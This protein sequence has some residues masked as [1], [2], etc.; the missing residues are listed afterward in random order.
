M[1]LDDDGR[2]RLVQPPSGKTFE[3]R[4]PGQFVRASWGDEREAQ[5]RKL[6]QEGYSCSQIAKQLGG[7]TRNAVIGKVH[8]LG[9]ALRGHSQNRTIPKKGHRTARNRSQQEYA[10]YLEKA[11]LGDRDGL[12]FHKGKTPV[13]IAEPFPPRQETDIARISFM[14]LEDGKHCKF[15]PGDPV[16]PYEKQFCGLDVIAPGAVYCPAHHARCNENSRPRNYLPKVM[17]GA[18]LGRDQLENVKEFEDAN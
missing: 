3:R 11:V 6:Y 9:L 12:S 7:V 16:G 13:S 2:I 14:D 1:S 17:L 4:G 15:I 8:R 10:F 18:T 5:L